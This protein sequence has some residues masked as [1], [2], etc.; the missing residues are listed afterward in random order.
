MSE[1]KEYLGDGVYV[2]FDGWGLWLTTE[3]GVRVTNEIFLE[4]E[5]FAALERYVAALKA[6]AQ[7]RQGELE[8]EPAD[9]TARGVHQG[10]LRRRPRGSG[11]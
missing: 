6:E 4:P 11:D 2:R 5:V 8:E 9:G 3:N 10:A 1:R 7:R